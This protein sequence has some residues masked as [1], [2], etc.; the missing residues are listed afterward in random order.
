[1]TRD[2]RH[3]AIEDE[4]ELPLLPPLLLPD[5]Y[6]AARLMLCKSVP[7]G[8]ICDFSN[9]S[10]TA[11]VF[12][13]MTGESGSGVG[14]SSVSSEP[15][16]AAKAGRPNGRDIVVVVCRLSLQGPIRFKVLCANQK[17]IWS[18]SATT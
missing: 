18:R 15:V 14:I 12:G 3:N 11:A 5:E 8:A 1:M 9:G 17:S 10:A 16:L 7:L 13:V 6:V 4:D 2:I